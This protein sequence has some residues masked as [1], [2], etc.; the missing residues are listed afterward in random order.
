MNFLKVFKITLSCGLFGILV[1]ITILLTM[2]YDEEKTTLSIQY[3]QR[4]WIEL[5]SFT[6]CS[7]NL[8][9]GKQPN[10]TFDEFMNKTSL[11]TDKILTANFTILTPH[12]Q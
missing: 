5:P 4:N 8:D 6:F 3:D 2:K 12:Q 11:M 10:M 9:Y 7:E 1:F